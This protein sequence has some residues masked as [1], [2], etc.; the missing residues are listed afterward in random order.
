MPKSKKSQGSKKVDLVQQPPP[1]A[2]EEESQDEDS[3]RVYELT[4]I[5]DE[6]IDRE[7]LAVDGDEDGLPGGDYTSAFSISVVG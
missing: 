1:E 6:I 4:V 3:R 2:S 7:G 5:G